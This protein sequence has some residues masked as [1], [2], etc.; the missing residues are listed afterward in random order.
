MYQVQLTKR[1]EK[2][3]LKAD[4]R[5]LENLRDHINKL[6]KNPYPH[7]CKK[8]EGSE[9]EY[10]LRVGIYRI[11]YVVQNEI[12]L[13]TVIDVDNRGSIYKKR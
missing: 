8:L 3:L 11:L 4:R 7:G 13:I 12:L 2:N 9:N 5:Y 10:R 6:R 1:A